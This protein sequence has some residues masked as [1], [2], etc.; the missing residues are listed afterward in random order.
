[1]AAD[2]MPVCGLFHWFMLFGR[3]ERFVMFLHLLIPLGMGSVGPIA[4]GPG[5]ESVPD[6]PAGKGGRLTGSRP[7][8][9]PSS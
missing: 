4:R 1:M 9:C 3:V 5:G 2:E 7:Q 6:E 8:N